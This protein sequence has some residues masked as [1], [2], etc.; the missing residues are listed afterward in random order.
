[1]AQGLPPDARQEIAYVRLQLRV[2]LLC[3]VTATIITVAGR[4]M[5]WKLGF[6]VVAVVLAAFMVWNV[7]RVWRGYRR[8][9]MNF[10]RMTLRGKM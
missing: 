10:W 7:Q 4:N 2:S 8:L 1:M 9:G 5:W 6:W 3:V